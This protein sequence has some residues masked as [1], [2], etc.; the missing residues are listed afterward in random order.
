MTNSSCLFLF[1]TSPGYEEHSGT[2]DDTE[3]YSLLLKAVRE[4][5]DELG[6][7]TGKFYG[8]SSA[9]PCGTSHIENIDIPTAAKYL[10]ELNLMT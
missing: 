6:E 5:L 1:F 3:S 2:P 8:L 10:T 4:H 7:K 9:L